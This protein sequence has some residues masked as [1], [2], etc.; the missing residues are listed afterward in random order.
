MNGGFQATGGMLLRLQG[1]ITFWSTT[2]EHPRRSWGTIR[3][4]GKKKFI[5]HLSKF[6]NL[7]EPPALGTVVSF[8]PHARAQPGRDAGRLG[9]VGGKSRSTDA[10]GCEE[11]GRKSL[12]FMPRQQNLWV[13][14]GSG[15]RPSPHY[16]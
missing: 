14:S 4:A 6:L 5:A 12:L 11:S 1:E 13:V 8:R 10:R 7:A 2:A 15:S 3:S 9:C 16:S